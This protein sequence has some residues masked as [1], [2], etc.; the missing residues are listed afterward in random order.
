MFLLENLINNFTY[1]TE[2]FI[3]YSLDYS[4][5]IQIAINL[6]LA[7]LIVLVMYFLGRR[8]RHF[9]LKKENILIDIAIGNIILGTGVFFLGTFSSLYPQVLIFTLLLLLLFS[10]ISIRFA[11]SGLLSLTKYFN[12]TYKDMRKNKL[13]AAFILLFIFLAFIRLLIPETR[14]DQYHTDLPAIYL[15]E[16]TIMIPSKEPIR[17]SASPLLS[18]MVYSIPVV[19]NQKE[20]ARYIHFLFY[21][22]CILALYSISKSKKYK[23][24]IFAP[25]LFAS[26]PEIIK[27]TSSQHADF[28][29]IFF[30]L[31][32]VLML[33][34][35]KS[36]NPKNIAISGFLFGGM[37]ATRLWTIPFIL[38]PLLYILVTEKILKDKL[39]RILIFLGLSLIAPSVWYLRSFILMGNPV[40]PAFS[41]VQTLETSFTI[42]YNLSNYIKPNSYLMNPDILKVFSPL[43]FL[44]IFLTIINFST[45]LKMLGKLSVSLIFLIFLIEISFLN[46]PYGRYLLGFYSIAVIVVSFQIFRFIKN[47]YFNLLFFSLSFLVFSYYFINSLLILPY[48]LGWADKNKYLTRVLSKDNSSYYDFNYSFDKFITKSDLVATYTV[49][50]YYYAN[51][52]YIDI[53]YIFNKNS[54]SFELLK[55][56]KVTK[57]FIKG[58]DMEWFCKK[59]SLTN[60][61]SGQYRLLSYYSAIPHSANEYYLYE[62]K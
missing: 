22:L 40:F 55:K 52:D 49:G 24:A 50:G 25:L 2:D 45:F 17:V 10:L 57:L 13:L 8:V 15:R 42:Q 34:S 5:F 53:N 51:F 46:Y 33:I 9:F 58:G 61:N 43:F 54:R 19:L 44:G 62:I 11:K 48:S 18:E 20:A 21:I 16:H 59:I 28:Q 27:E 41:P 31:T 12:Q 3:G 14:E 4:F 47:K 32:S 6:L 37:L 60:C 36:L 39:R 1:L 38:V 35:N 30:L 26:A 23:F 29:I 56:N 7:F